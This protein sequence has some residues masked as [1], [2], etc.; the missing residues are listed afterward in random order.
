MAAP[1]RKRVEADAAPRQRKGSIR[2]AAADDRAA[3]S[4]ALDQQAALYQHWSP[5]PHAVAQSGKWS[6]R[7]TLAFVAV[8]CGG[9]WALVIFGAARLA[10]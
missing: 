5:P 7:R 10:H 1:S 9:F 3:P 6:H 8:T 2:L 4:P